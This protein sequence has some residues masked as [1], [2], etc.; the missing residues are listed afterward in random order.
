MTGLQVGGRYHFV[1]DRWGIRD[2][3]DKIMR[4]VRSDVEGL[5][6]FFLTERET[7][8]ANYQEGLKRLEL[9]DHS[10]PSLGA[11]LGPNGS[12]VAKLEFGRLFVR[13]AWL[14]PQFFGSQANRLLA[15]RAFS[16]ISD[17]AEALSGEGGTLASVL[18]LQYLD[19]LT[20]QRLNVIPRAED[21]MHSLA[22]TLPQPTELYVKV[23]QERRFRGLNNFARGQELER[24][25]WQSPESGL[26]ARIFR[27]YA[28]V[29]AY[30]S[31]RR[32]FAQ[33]RSNLVDP[34]KVSNG[35]GKEVYMLGYC[36][37]DKALREEALKASS[38]G[39]LSDLMLQ[40]WE[41]AMG[42][43]S[44]DLAQLVDDLIERYETNQGQN[45]QGRRLQR[46]LPLLPALRDPRHP[47]REAALGHFGPDQE[48]IVLRWIWIEQ[49]KIPVAD[50]IRL[51]GGR[52]N[53]HFRNVLI[54]YLD[55]D[56]VKTLAALNSFSRAKRGS[57]EKTLL[58][59]HL[60]RKLR[61]VPV[62]GEQIDLK[63]AGAKSIREA[64]HEK[65]RSSHK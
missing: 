36:T 15:G 58:A 5:S 1:R 26:E 25:Y 18:V 55:R 29:G 8:I 35:L 53:D 7:D 42:D 32:F 47:S 59:A 38:S 28:L 20:A 40:I 33:I 52:E 3:A 14:R 4:T 30:E 24:L 57:D 34:V 65:L 13:R 12:D 51:L 44:K 31:A 39:S 10:F 16:E 49:F 19:G 63:P 23:V 43:R 6:S 61:P 62:P 60:Y 56:E 17:L 48:W 54:A 46:F 22:E 50:A 27:N 11:D 21:L 2:E 41:A 9:L 45:S 37:Q 64:V